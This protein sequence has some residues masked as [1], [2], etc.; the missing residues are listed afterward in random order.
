MQLKNAR[1]PSVSTDVN[2]STGN[3]FSNSIFAYYSEIHVSGD[4][5]P[6]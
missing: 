2:H 1:A 6:E 3:E 4:W 5:K